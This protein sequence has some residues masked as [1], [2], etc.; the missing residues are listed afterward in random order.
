MRW[1][2]LALSVI[3]PSK[4]EKALPWLSMLRST[5]PMRARLIFEPGD[6]PT[7]FFNFFAGQTAPPLMLID[8]QRA[9]LL[10]ISMEPN[11]S[12]GRIEFVYLFL[13]RSWHGLD[14]KSS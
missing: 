13:L 4:R 9:K 12:H 2:T 11:R 10:A 1:L 6:L 14:F 3:L 8:V 5:R 7:Q